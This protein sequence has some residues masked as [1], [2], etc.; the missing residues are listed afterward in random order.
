MLW[1]SLFKV[2]AYIIRGLVDFLRRA[3]FERF[4]IVVFFVG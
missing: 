2:L 3:C 1:Y 4:A